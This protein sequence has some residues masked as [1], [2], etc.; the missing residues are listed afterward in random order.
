VIYAQG[1][2]EDVEEFVENVKGM[3][4][5]ALRLRFL[6]ALPDEIKAG[7]RGDEASLEGW[8]E[9]QKVGEVMEEMRRIGRE[10]YV[11]EMGIG[12]AGTGTSS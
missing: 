12:S 10:K 3:Q 7:S 1:S 2:K 8:K 6:E 4:W 11:V 5:L 9:L